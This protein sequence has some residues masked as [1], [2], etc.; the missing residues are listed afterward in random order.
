MGLPNGV[1]HLAIATK[2]IKKQIEFFTQ[3]VGGE[4]VA[5]YWM[6]GVDNTFHGF[7]NFGNGCS[8]AFVQS[9]E[10]GEIQPQKGVS[11][12]AWTASPVAAGALEHL[13]RVLGLGEGLDGRPL[14]AV[15]LAAGHRTTP[16]FPG[17]VARRR[18]VPIVSGTGG[19]GTIADA[20]AR[21]VAGPRAR[22]EVVRTLVAAG[23]PAAPVND[24]AEMVADPQ[25]SAREMFVELDHPIYGP[26]RTTGTPLKLS[27]TPGRVRWLDQP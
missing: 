22:A 19:A 20:A 10:I 3:T 27:E 24:V 2:D 25:V 23:V 7:V 18:H 16:D 21:V 9:P 1:H 8:L 12:A 15:P 5:L 4:L 6:H 17:A 11:H 26:L 14:V 13:P